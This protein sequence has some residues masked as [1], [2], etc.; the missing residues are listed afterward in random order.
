MYSF[1]SF[2]FSE[3]KC[4]KTINYSRGWGI[5]VAIIRWN[6]NNINYIITKFFICWFI[7]PSFFF[8]IRLLFLGCMFY[9]CHRLFTVRVRSNR[10]NRPKRHVRWH[11]FSH[12]GMDDDDDVL[13]R[14]WVG[15]IDLS[16]I[17]DRGHFINQVLFPAYLVPLSWFV[18]YMHCLPFFNVLQISSNWNRF[19]SLIATNF[20][21]SHLIDNTNQF[22]TNYKMSLYFPYI[23]FNLWP[24]DYKW[25]YFSYR[26]T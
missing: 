18:T 8:F 10:L 11:Q 1:G 25:F 5:F 6:I 24:L 19:C 2:T 4:W 23:Q 9:R 7:S 21:I 12:C 20:L 15:N 22:L 3:L 16:H 13:N 26:C 17:S 14:W